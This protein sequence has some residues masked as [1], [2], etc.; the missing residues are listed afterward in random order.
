MYLFIFKDK[1]TKCPKNCEN[2]NGV[3]LKINNAD[4]KKFNL[5]ESN[6]FKAHLSSADFS[7]SNLYFSNF[8]ESVLKGSNFYYSNLRG[9]NFILSDLTLSNL[10]GA[11]LRGARLFKADLRGSNLKG[12]NFI[13]ADL[14][15]SKLNNTQID[16]HTKMSDKWINVWNVVNNIKFFNKKLAGLNLN[17]ANLE[18]ITFEYSPNELGVLEE[19]Q[20]NINSIKQ[21]RPLSNNQPWGIFFIDFEPDI[22]F[23]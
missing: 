17:N 18:N 1:L 12:V 7:N 5:S 16:K 6:F 20:V 13:A 14:R 3:K 21:L 23:C 19:H 22:S 9:A 8:K 4:F 15:L 2:Y 11:D 10:H